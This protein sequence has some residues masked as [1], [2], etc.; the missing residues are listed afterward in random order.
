MGVMYIAEIT[1]ELNYPGWNLCWTHPQ[2]TTPLPACYL[3]GITECCSPVSDSRRK[4][5]SPEK[6]VL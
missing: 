5:S 4:K 3:V 6:R 2:L 1:G